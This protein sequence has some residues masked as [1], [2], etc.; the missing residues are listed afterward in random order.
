MSHLQHIVRKLFCN[1]KKAADNCCI[2]PMRDIPGGI[3]MDV[4]KRHFGVIY[5]AM[6]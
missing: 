5:A 4:W 3:E 6:Q 2:A 1:D